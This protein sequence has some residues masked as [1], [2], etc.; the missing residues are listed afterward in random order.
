MDTFT[1]HRISGANLAHIMKHHE[2]DFDVVLNNELANVYYMYL[3]GPSVR[4]PLPVFSLI[5]RNFDYIS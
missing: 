1:E 4:L 5:W 3:I 2:N